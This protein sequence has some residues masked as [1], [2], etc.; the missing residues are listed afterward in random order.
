MLHEKIRLKA[1]LLIF[2]TAP[3]W[4]SAY[5]RTS[6]NQD[7]TSRK[8]KKWTHIPTFMCGTQAHD[9]STSAVQTCMCYNAA[10]PPN[11]TSLLHFAEILNLIVPALQY[12]SQ[13]S[14]C[15]GTVIVPVMFLICIL[16]VASLNLNQI[17][18]YPDS[19]LL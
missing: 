11:G 1:L 14:K 13:S 6:A 8:K 16:E 3:G 2:G 17:T 5:H 4:V 12:F 7:N 19:E 18:D 15:T 9:P 10:Q